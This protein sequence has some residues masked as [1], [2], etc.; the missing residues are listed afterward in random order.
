[1]RADTRLPRVLM[2]ADCVG[3]V[4]TYAVDLAGALTRRGAS[5]TSR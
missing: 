1:M 5:V 4:W 3:G 2:T